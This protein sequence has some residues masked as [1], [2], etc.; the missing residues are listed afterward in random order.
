MAIATEAELGGRDSLRRTRKSG[1]ANETV[2]KTRRGFGCDAHADVRI[3]VDERGERITLPP[4]NIRCSLRRRMLTYTREERDEAR[5][6][7]GILGWVLVDHG[8][9]IM[10]AAER[11]GASHAGT[12]SR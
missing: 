2:K 4:M 11:R 8:E 9:L 10:R 12:A 6:A 1:Q 7:A 5:Q 3:G